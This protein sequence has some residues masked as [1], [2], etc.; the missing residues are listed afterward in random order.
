MRLLEKSADPLSPAVDPYMVEASCFAAAVPL[1]EG[2][3]A[4]GR[5]EIH[6]ISLWYNPAASG[7]Y[8][9]PPSRTLLSAFTF[10][11]L[12]EKELRIA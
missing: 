6:S 11:A 4:T 7:S 12:M 10:R 1:D 9:D 8:K 5:I 2:T 3:P